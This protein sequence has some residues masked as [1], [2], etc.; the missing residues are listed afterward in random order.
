MNYL[1]GLCIHCHMKH[2]QCCLFL[3]G[4]LQSNHAL[5]RI[6]EDSQHLQPKVIIINAKKKRQC[7]SSHQCSVLVFSHCFLVA[8]VQCHTNNLFVENHKHEN[9]YSRTHLGCCPLQIPFCSQR[10][11]A[12]PT[13]PYPL[14]H[15]KLTLLP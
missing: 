9:Q 14:L 8:V 11:C 10:R 1:D 6:N 13:R 2:G 15:E 4:I 12:E 5:E 7:Y 3:G